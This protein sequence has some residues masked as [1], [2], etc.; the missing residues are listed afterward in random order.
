MCLIGLAEGDAPIS[1]GAWL[2][3]EIS[4]TSSLAYFREEF[5]MAMGMIADG[6]VQV[7]PL[8][9]STVGLDG[10]EAALAD[11]ASGTSDQ[12]KVLVDPNR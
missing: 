11:L 4:V 12:A 7:D 3:K 2:I 6:R 5:E 8:H 10:F 9:S 1:P